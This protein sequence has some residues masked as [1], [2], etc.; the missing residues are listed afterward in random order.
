MLFHLVA[1]ASNLD[2]LCAVLSLDAEKPFDCLEWEYL[3]LVQFWG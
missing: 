1:E 2:T 3:W